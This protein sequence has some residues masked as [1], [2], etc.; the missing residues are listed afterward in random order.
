MGR[1]RDRGR[2]RYFIGDFLDLKEAKE[3]RKKINV[4]GA[5]VVRFR[6]GKKQ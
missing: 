2:Y 5:F 1:C 3:Y 6:N 4:K